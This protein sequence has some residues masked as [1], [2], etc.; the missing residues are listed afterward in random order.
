MVPFLTPPIKNRV[1]CMRFYYLPDISFQRSLLERLSYFII[2]MLFTFIPLHAANEVRPN[3]TLLLKMIPEQETWFTKNIIRPFEKNQGITINIKHFQDY[4][5]LDSMLKADS[6]IDVIKVPMERAETF[7]DRG[8]ITPISSIADSSTLKT[9]VNDFI[10]PPLAIADNE[11]YYVPRK[12]ETRI[13]V[14]RVSKVQEALKKYKIYLPQLRK[15]L[16]QFNGREFPLDYSLKPDPNQ[17]DYLD[18]LVLGYTWARMDSTNSNPGKI[19][20]RGKNY[21][22]TFL[23]M[24]DRAFQFGAI[25]GEIPHLKSKPVTEVFTWE[26]VYAKFKAYNTSM[27]TNAWTGVD[28]WKALGKEEIYLSF[29]TQ[30]DCFFLIGTG[31]NNIRGFVKNPD[32]VDFAVMPMAVSIT[33]EDFLLANR[34]ISTGGW[35]WAI[36]HESKSK[37][38]ALKLILEMTSE[39][40]QKKEFEAF[41]VLSARKTLM[42]EN[43]DEFYLKRWRNRMLQT[44]IKQVNLNRFTVVPTYA[45]MEKLQDKYYNVLFELCTRTNQIHGIENVM[46]V[47]SR[48]DNETMFGNDSTSSKSR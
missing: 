17:W 3:I 13:M 39:D 19:G 35:F 28:L 37:P 38:L 45:D 18:L 47:I 40:N 26:C 1:H 10:L 30:L 11:L 41:G 6:S 22:G 29:L 20:L 9:I 33:G 32:D 27:F 48:Y 16:K 14:Y 34:N 2:P 21:P 25:R 15:S 46:S 31:E 7:R 44:S 43:E 8:Y 36:D 23:T 24:M 5:D 12:L 4:N 42:Q